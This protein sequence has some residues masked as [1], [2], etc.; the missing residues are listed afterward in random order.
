VTAIEGLS[1]KDLDDPQGFA[2]QTIR[3]L[4]KSP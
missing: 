3:R 4:A 1:I 2:A